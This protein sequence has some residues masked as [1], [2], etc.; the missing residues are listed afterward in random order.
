EGYQLLR[1]SYSGRFGGLR[2]SFAAV[3]DPVPIAVG[4]WADPDSPQPQSDKADGAESGGWMVFAEGTETVHLRLAISYLDLD[5]AR[6]V[7][8]LELPDLGFD[9]RWEEAKDEWR[10]ELGVVR[11]AGGTES[12]RRIFHTA[13]YHAS[14]MPSL[15]YG[16]D[17]K[18]RGL[19]QEIHQVDFDYYTDFSLWDTFRTLHPWYVLVQP[20]RQLDMVRSLVQM[21]KDG[22][23]VPR[24]PLGHGYTS[25]MVGTPADQVFAGSFLKGLDE[26]WDVDFAFEACF[27]HAQ[28]P[29]AHAGRSGIASYVNKGYVSF[30]AASSPASRTLEFVWSDYALGLWGEALGYEEEAAILMAQSGNWR[31]TWDAEQGFFLGRFADGTFIENENSFAWTESFVE[32]NAYHYQWAVPFDAEG[33]VEVTSQGDF[34]AFAE[35]YED[36]W[37]EV[38]AEPDDVYPDD[39]YWHG[40][41]PDIHYAF[42]GS[43]VGLPDQSALASRWVLENRYHDAW[44]GL[45]GN[46]DGGT[47]SAW[48]L[49]AAMGLFP[50]AGTP[51]Y[52]VGSP[53]FERIEIDRFDGTIIIKA[54]GVSDEAKYVES[55][56]LGDE[57]LTSPRFTHDQLMEAGEL[58]LQMSESAGLWQVD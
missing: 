8:E 25:G 10:E 22:G 15:F 34:G 7:R 31:N 2:T 13:Q 36:F 21:T 51:D 26:G 28:N 53:I 24:W 3:V 27:D 16:M 47:L 43:M 56:Q 49:F 58:V 42:L 11:V 32:G 20:E 4:T 17:G 14:L 1:G 5:D 54:P 38:M 39:Y 18:Y 30:E 44:E 12:Q 37:D 33:L 6:A 45:D 57:A 52:V 35:E 23:A 41:E 46:D 55:A 9:A 50:I 19:D 29:V 40:N 48:Y